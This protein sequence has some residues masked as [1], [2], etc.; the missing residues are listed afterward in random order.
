L[1]FQFLGDLEETQRDLPSIA[2]TEVQGDQHL[3]LRIKFFK[4]AY[5]ATCSWLSASLENNDITY[6]SLWALLKPRMSVFMICP[7][8]QQPRCIEHITGL[9]QKTAQWRGVFPWSS[10]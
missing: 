3:E 7:A 5:A 1:I 4:K 2:S 6:D 8:L 10:D 9:Q